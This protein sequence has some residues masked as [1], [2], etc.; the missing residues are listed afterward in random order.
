MFTIGWVAE[1]AI[2]IV[3]WS[4]PLFSLI[5]GYDRG[6]NMGCL[7]LLAAKLEDSELQ[8]E[9]SNLS[10]KMLIFYFLRQDYNLI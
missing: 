9:T 1:P 5:T 8:L 6:V 7:P 3:D 2:A 10:C 4:T